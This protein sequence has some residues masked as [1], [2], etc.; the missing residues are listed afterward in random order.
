MSI[1]FAQSDSSLDQIRNNIIFLVGIITFILI[2]IGFVVRTLSSAHGSVKSDKIIGNIKSNDSEERNQAIKDLSYSKWNIKIKSVTKLQNIINDNS[3][4]I[5]IRKDA[6]RALDT[7]KK[8]LIRAHNAQFYDRVPIAKALLKINDSES[9]KA[10][11]RILTYNLKYKNSGVRKEAIKEIA[12]IDEPESLTSL[13]YVFRDESHHNRALAIQKVLKRQNQAIEPLII[14]LSHTDSNIKLTSIKLLGKIGD[15][16]A[17][18]PLIKLLKDEDPKIRKRAAK[19]LGS[20]NNKIAIE[21]LE[22][23]IEKETKKSNQKAMK[24]SLYK[25][26]HTPKSN[27]EKNIHPFEKNNNQMSVQTK[28]KKK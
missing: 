13:I 14:S 15:D 20:I 1:S 10:A 26:M 6:E 28:T 9:R 22:I 11:V 16:K 4:S 21:P 23:A 2:I 19:A 7:L 17:V 18:K 8:E 27:I 25:L 12:K 3:L 24:K 5:E